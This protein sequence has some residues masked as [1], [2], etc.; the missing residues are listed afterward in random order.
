MQVLKNAVTALEAKVGAWDLDEAPPVQIHL[1]ITPSGMETP[2]SE[3][4]HRTDNGAQHTV[5][6]EFDAPR[7]PEL[8]DPEQP[9]GSGG[10]RPGPQR[11][12][13]VGEGVSGSAQHDGVLGRANAPRPYACTDQR[14]WQVE[15]KVS[16]CFPISFNLEMHI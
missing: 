5:Q 9:S 11:L 15:I 6:H 4:S 13:A 10:E 8:W 1:S 3:A 2:S 7:A 12:T 16:I 14:Y